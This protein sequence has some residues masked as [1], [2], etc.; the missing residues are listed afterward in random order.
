MSFREKWLESVERNNSVLCAG[1]DPAPF[2]MGRGPKGLPEGVDKLGWSVL[3]LRAVAPYCAAVKPNKQYWSEP[4]DLKRLEDIIDIADYFGLVKIW[5]AK[6]ADIG[7]TNEAGFYS[8]A[9]M[10]FDAVTVA[11]YAGNLEEMAEQASKW[12]IGA[13][14]MCLMSNPEYETEKNKLVTVGSDYPESLVWEDGTRKVKQYMV[15]AKMSNDLGFSAMVIGAPS[16][17]NHL[18]DEELAIAS[19]LGGDIRI[20][21]PGIG[22]QG[23]KA[24]KMYT[25]F[26][27]DQLIVNVGRALMLPDGSY[28]TPQQQTGAAI[29]YRDMLNRLREA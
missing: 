17:N 20:L 4:G 13:I 27:A 8:A 5:D 2:E 12:G 18:T 7:S 29:H 14:P 25:Y 6:L 22:A 16:D 15:L 3:Y 9:K 1:L 19:E 23:G 26:G 28:T 11:P 21:A 24:K 10:G